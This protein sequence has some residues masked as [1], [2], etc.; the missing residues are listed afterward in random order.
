MTE[1]RRT[2]PEAR[3][4]LRT[5]KAKLSNASF[6]DR[7]PAAVVE[8]HRAREKNFAEQLQKMKEALAALE[9]D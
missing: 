9:G 2:L 7:V 8:E 1:W 6:V 5:V 4:E 3:G